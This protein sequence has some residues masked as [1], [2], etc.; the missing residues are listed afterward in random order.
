[1]SSDGG[2]LML[3]DIVNDGD[4]WRVYFEALVS[5]RIRRIT[6]RVRGRRVIDIQADDGGYQW[7]GNAG[8]RRL[9]NL[10]T[11]RAL[12]E[13]VRLRAVKLIVVAAR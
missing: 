1:M 4:E 3:R 8:D 9:T 10:A 2:T 12:E 5:G 13:I 7:A 11:D 6:V